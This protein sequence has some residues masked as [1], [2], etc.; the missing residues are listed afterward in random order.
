MRLQ[1]SLSFISILIMVFYLITFSLG[2]YEFF[3]Y[4]LIILQITNLS[5]VVL[6]FK[7]QSRKITTYIIILI[8]FII[9]TACTYMLVVGHFLLV[10]KGPIKV[11]N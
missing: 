4:I 7:N 2:D 9:I 11:I 10:G 3:F 6:N 5:I 8:S 1:K